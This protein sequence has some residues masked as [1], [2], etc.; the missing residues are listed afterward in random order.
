MNHLLE[1]K[2]PYEIV[3]NVL[4]F[5]RHPVAELLQ[6]LI[7]THEH[8]KDGFRAHCDKKGIPDKSHTFEFPMVIFM[9]RRIQMGNKKG[10]DS[11]TIVKQNRYLID[12]Y[13]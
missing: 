2:L 12:K 7:K 10:K 6:P 8:H 13:Y 5:S 3:I 1:Q 9:D 4:K 11:R